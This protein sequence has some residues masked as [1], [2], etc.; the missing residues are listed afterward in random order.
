MNVP[1][2]L[3]C[4]GHA[5]PFRCIR[6][7]K[8]AEVQVG[9]SGQEILVNEFGAHWGGQVATVNGLLSGAA[10][11]WQLLPLQDCVDVAILAVKT[12]A[13]I[14]KFV[15]DIRGVGGPIDVAVITKTDGFRYLQSKSLRGEY[16]SKRI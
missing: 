1:A 10:I 11:P 9:H 14:Q 8:I 6:T 4:F 12:T 16:E 3:F 2:S 15:T 13:E 5:L 7:S